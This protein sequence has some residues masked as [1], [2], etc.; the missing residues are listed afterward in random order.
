MPFRFGRN[1]RRYLASLE[2][3]QIV[4][5]CADLERSTGSLAGESFLDIG[6]GSGI[7]SLA[8]LRLGA[9]SVVAFDSDPLCV[10]TARRCAP[11]ARVLHGSILD[12]IFVR[13]LE[14]SDVVYSWGVLH[15]TGAMWRAIQ[16]ATRLVR[17]GG[18][19]CIAIYNRVWSSTIWRAVKRVIARF[20][21]GVQEVLASALFL[22]RAIWRG[23]TGRDPLRDRRG[24]SVW[25]DALDWLGGTP[26]EFAS[27]EEVMGFL[28]R[29]GFATERVLPTRGTG[30]NEFI[31]RAPPGG[32]ECPR[33]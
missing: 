3:A 8:A 29:R 15:H 23:I 10:Q 12:A 1:W 14:P 30:C 7:A 2:D 26:Y 27:V 19:L 18:L 31:F 16:Q 21:E 22:P 11:G 20:P 13:S 9:R 4:S 28:G 5:A 24:M 33:E 17:P 6:C 32:S 25:H